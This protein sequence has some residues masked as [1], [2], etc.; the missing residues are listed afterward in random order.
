[1][2]PFPTRVASSVIIVLGNGHT[3]KLC[4]NGRTDRDAVRGGADSCGPRNVI[5]DKGSDPPH[6]GTLLRGNTCP[7]TVKC[8][9]YGGCSA[10]MWPFAKLLWTLFSSILFIFLFSCFR[11]PSYTGRRSI[12][13]LT[14]PSVCVCVPGGG[15]LRPTCRQFL[16]I[17]GSVQYSGQLTTDNW[18]YWSHLQPWGAELL[19][20]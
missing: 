12:M 4:K 10:A 16:V 20:N 13:F 7:P 9:D 2:R 1:M 5:L 6:K 17:F 14:C 19:N 3:D 15:S 18:F 8:W 11:R